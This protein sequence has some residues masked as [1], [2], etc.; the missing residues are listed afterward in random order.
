MRIF[1]MIS[2]WL[3]SFISCYSQKKIQLID[4]LNNSNYQIPNNDF[5]LFNVE[6]KEGF[7][8]GKIDFSTLQKEA[9]FAICCMGRI[10]PISVAYYYKGY[11]SGFIQVGNSN[12]AT[13]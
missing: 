11:T 10:P 2:L 12:F 8:T 3:F 7:Y 1:F 13:F 9:G 4:S 6:N 5:I